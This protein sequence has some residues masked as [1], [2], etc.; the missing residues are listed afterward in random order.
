MPCTSSQQHSRLL[1]PAHQAALPGRN[2]LAQRFASCGT[3]ASACCLARA[4]SC[5]SVLHVMRTTWQ[6]TVPSH[7]QTLCLS[8]Q[9][10]RN[11][12]SHEAMVRVGVLLPLAELTGWWTQLCACVL[13]HT[14]ILPNVITYC[15]CHHYLLLYYY[16]TY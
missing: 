16:Y 4:S 8:V 11:Q 2:L 15:C 10:S 6:R 3:V 7:R 9:S 1:S 13:V 14:C 12:Q 5:T